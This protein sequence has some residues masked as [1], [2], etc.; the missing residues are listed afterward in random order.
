MAVSWSDLADSGG[1]RANVPVITEISAPAFVDLWPKVVP[2]LRARLRRRGVPVSSI[3]DVLQETALAAWRG[4]RPFE[5][6]GHLL[7]WA[8]TVS[9]RLAVG[10][11]RRRGRLTDAAAPDDIV[12]DVEAQALARVDLERAVAGIAALDPQE[13]LDLVA[14]GA[15]DRKEA[16]RLNVRRHRARKKLLLLMGGLGSGIGFVLRRLRDLGPVSPPMAAVSAVVAVLG[17]VAADV[18]PWSAGPPPPRGE[19]RLETTPATS[20]PA[21]PVEAPRAA[22]PE[23]ATAGAVLTERPSPTPPRVAGGGPAIAVDPPVDAVDDGRLEA[24][25]RAEEEPPLCLKAGTP[26]STCVTAPFPQTPLDD[27]TLTE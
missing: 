25:P 26:T 10:D 18:G 17:L 22:E 12:E 19:V 13:Q 4:G 1:S 14:G 8:T 5:D 3:D 20:A 27:L 23:A 9:R 16:V 7:A 15:T 21:S 11:Y 2:L 6:E 24:R